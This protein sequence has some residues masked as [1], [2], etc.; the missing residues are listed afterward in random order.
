MIR[1]GIVGAENSHSAAIARTLNVA[2]A[3]PGFRVVAIWGETA[4]FAQRSAEAGQIPKIV[5]RPAD[6]IGHID[7][8]MI[9]HRHAKYHLSAAEP[10]LAAHVE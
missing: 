2:K 4:A 6:M 9:D 10:F 8:V 5:K 7:G 1:V 3:V